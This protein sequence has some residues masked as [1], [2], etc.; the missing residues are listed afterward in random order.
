M[1]VTLDSRQRAALDDLGYVVL[2]DLAGVHA[3]AAL[4]EAFERVAAEQKEAG[5]REGG[6]RHVRLDG[7]EAF[8]FMPEDSQ[9]AEVALHVIA[10]PFGVL[11]WGGR[12][13]LPGFGQ[14]GLHADWRPRAVWEPFHVATALWL[15]DDFT[16]DNGATRVVP[17]SHRRS[18]VPKSFAGP[19]S[20]H[21][22]EKG[23]VARAGSVLVF[24]GHLWHRGTQNRTAR[25]R[26]VVQCVYAGRELLSPGGR[27][28]FA[29]AGEVGEQPR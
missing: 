6:T 29:E 4:R 19:G 8:A 2:P 17:R 22:E 1:I 18:A 23:I 9:V 10:R 25:T 3:L 15:L 20:R 24:N 13:P 14:Q 26:R 21:P 7:C 28:P 11:N 27:T 16:P 5:A 12:D